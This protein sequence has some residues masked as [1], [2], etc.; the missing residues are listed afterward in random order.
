MRAT[1]MPARASA[2]SFAC[3]R[4]LDLRRLVSPHPHTHL[5]PSLPFPARATEAANRS[6]KAEKAAAKTKKSTGKTKVGKPIG[7]ISK[8]AKGL[9]G[10][11]VGL[12]GKGKGKK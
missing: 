6:A 12:K 3:G 2:P 9:K 10:K 5:I 1:P 7:A 8:G 11:G 4:W